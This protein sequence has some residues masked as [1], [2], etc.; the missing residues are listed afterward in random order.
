MKR[1]L[2]IIIISIIILMNF[3]LGDAIARVMKS[4]GDVSLR[5]LGETTF[6]A[7]VKAGRGINNGD[8][9]RIG[10]T[11]FAVVIFIDDK[12]IVKI[13]ENTEFQFIDTPT[14]R[15]LDLEHGTILNKVT[16]QRDKTFQVETP[17]SVASVKGTEFAVVSDP[18]GVDQF[19]CN[20]GLF[21]VYNTVSGETV[22]VPAGQQA[23]SNALGT[24]A[25]QPFNPNDYPT[26]PAPDVTTGEEGTIEEEAE[27]EETETEDIQ[28]P[29]ESAEPSQT[30]PEPQPEPIEPPQEEPP[31]PEG[32]EPFGMGLGIG[33]VTIDGVLYNQFALRPE[34]SFGKFGIGLD[35]VLYIDNEGNVRPNEWDIKNNPSVLL[36]KI[37]YLRWGQKQDPL[38][39]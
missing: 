4:N 13:R 16:K 6:S 3:V 32:G 36:D 35:L 22:S 30:Q 7:G 10:E 19:F 29:E 31:A 20:E 28:Q 15:T 34:F 17:V 12:S 26:D 9:I 5:G 11:G 21:D 24:L 23:I 33:S 27:P 2:S 37:L 39:D 1:I 8:A 25:Q 18:S 14:T 38:L